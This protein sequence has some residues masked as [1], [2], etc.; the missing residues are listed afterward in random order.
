MCC[1]CVQT[2]DVMLLYDDTVKKGW[3][4]EDY[5]LN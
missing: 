2:D 5:K 3:A 4:E 1:E